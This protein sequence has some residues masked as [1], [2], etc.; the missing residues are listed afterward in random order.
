M[1]LC[2]ELHYFEKHNKERFLTHSLSVMQPD[3][4]RGPRIIT[5]VCV[6]DDHVSLDYISF[7]LFSELRGSLKPPFVSVS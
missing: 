3:Y 5:F 6:T 2:T 1:L 4:W 7:L